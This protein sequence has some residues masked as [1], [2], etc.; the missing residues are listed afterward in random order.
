MT[1]AAIRLFY[2]GIICRGHNPLTCFRAK[3]AIYATYRLF[4]TIGYLKELSLSLLARLV[5]FGAFRVVPNSP[6]C[7]KKMSVNHWR[8]WRCE[9]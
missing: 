3:R 7:A 2:G 5:F 6:K 1:G 4:G 8:S 9:D